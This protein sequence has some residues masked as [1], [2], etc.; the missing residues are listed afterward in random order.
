MTKG[1]RLHKMAIEFEYTDDSIDE[2]QKIEE[3]EEVEEVEFNMTEDEI[4]EWINE[5][6]ILKEERKTINLQIDDGLYLKI[7]Y[8][9]EEEE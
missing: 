6:M 7:N 8:E 9:Q 3:C 4:D 1:R 5:L 2:T